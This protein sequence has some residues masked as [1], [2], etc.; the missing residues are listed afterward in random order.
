[1][2]HGSTIR[3]TTRRDGDSFVFDFG[4]TTE[5]VPLNFNAPP[6]ITRAAVLYVLRCLVDD[7]IPLNAG[8]LRPIEIMIPSGSLLNPR[9]PSAVVAGN[10]ETSQCIV[11]T[12]LA[13]LG[14]Q[15]VSFVVELALHCLASLAIARVLTSFGHLA[16]NWTGWSGVRV[17]ACGRTQQSPP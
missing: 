6:A 8:C 5:Q 16:L 4:G 9:S 11:D 2:D 14:V 7:D 3:V 15:A 17:V 13:A 1:M 10:V 12:V